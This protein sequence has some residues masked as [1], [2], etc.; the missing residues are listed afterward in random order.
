MPSHPLAADALVHLFDWPFARCAAELPQLAAAGYTA[1]QIS[2][3]QLSLPRADW[4]ARYQP[5]D[6]RRIEGPLGSEADLRALCAQ[7]TRLGL[8][9]I[10]DV[11]FNHMASGDGYASH[12]RYPHFGPE[13][14]RPR[15]PID[16]SDLRSIREGWL[17]GLPDLRTDHPHVRAE[18]RRH[19]ELLLDCGVRGFRFDAVKHMEPEFF[20]AV[21]E[22]LDP[23]LLMFGEYIWQPGHDAALADFRAR[24]PLMDFELHR[25]LGETLKGERGWEPLD[26]WAGDAVVFVTNHDIELAQYQGFELPVDGLDLAHAFTTARLDGVPHVW[27]E[28]RA[29][30]VVRAALRLRRA[31]AAG[32]GWETLHAGAQS[33]VWRARDGSALLVLNG[34]HAPRHVAQEWLG[35]GGWDAWQDLLGSGPVLASRQP[36][37]YL[38]A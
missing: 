20:D 26:A 29:H 8:R 31:A 12:L 13:H 9:V 4:W 10:G 22:G 24:L 37:L 3:A 33:L 2:P 14:F 21:L 5:V 16:Y 17:A 27:L 30:P 32:G 15:V 34:A 11:V 7:A 1:I 38:R 36:G 25:A 18:A 19:L 6:H 35:E 23:G 28:H